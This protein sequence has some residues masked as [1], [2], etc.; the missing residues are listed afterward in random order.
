MTRSPSEDDDDRAFAAANRSRE[1]A[2]WEALARSV[3]DVTV[4]ARQ[5][6][7]LDAPWTVYLFGSEDSRAADRPY[8][9]LDPSGRW[10]L[11]DVGPTIYAV[12]DRPGICRASNAM[13]S[14]VRFA[15]IEGLS[16]E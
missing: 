1:K 14:R 5:Q 11:G 15:L 4:Q 2:N 10:E 3:S 6:G 16:Q 12:S 8:V 13:V 7:L 9:T